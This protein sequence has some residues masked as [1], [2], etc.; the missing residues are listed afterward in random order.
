M[1]PPLGVFTPQVFHG[2]RKIN[3]NHPLPHSYDPKEPVRQK[4]ITET[5]ETLKLILPPQAIDTPQE[6]AKLGQYVVNIV[7]FRDPDNAITIWSN[8]DIVHRPAYRTT[9]GVD[10]PPSIHLPPRLLDGTIDPTFAAEGTDPLVHYG[11]EYQPVALNEVLAFQTQYA[12]PGATGTAPSTSLA[13]NVMYIELANTLTEAAGPASTAS[14]LD[15]KGW[16]FLLVKEDPT[17]TYTAADPN[18]RPVYV[19]PDPITGQTPRVDTST[20]TSPFLPED[21]TTATAV[22]G[23]VLPIIVGSGKSPDLTDLSTRKTVYSEAAA[24]LDPPVDAIDA[25]GKT[26]YTVLGGMKVASAPPADLAAITNDMPVPDKEFL[27]V[28]V[29]GTGPGEWDDFLP[30]TTDPAFNNPEGLYFWL[31]LRRPANPI[32]PPDPSTNPMVVVDSIR[33][34]FSMTDAK[35]ETANVTSPPLPPNYQDR[36]VAGRTP[37]QPLYSIER[38]QPFRGG[39]IVPDPEDPTRPLFIYG[40][41]LQARASREAPK[42]YGLYNTPAPEA[43]GKIETTLKLEQTIDRQNNISTL[44]AGTPANEAWDFM[45]FND[46]DFVSVAELMLVPAC[47][48]GLFTK[49]FAEVPPNVLAAYPPP[50]SP[51]TIALQTPPTATSGPIPKAGDPGVLGPIAHTQARTYPYLAHEFYYSSDPTYAIDPNGTIPPDPLVDDRGH[52]VGG[53]TAAG[54]HR[55]LGFFE[56][57]APNLGA[58]GPVAQGI[59]LDWYR[60]DRRP[61]LINPNLIVD[62]EVFFG[63][64]D[65]P[66]LLNASDFGTSR[67]PNAALPQ[68][69]TQVNVNG[70]PINVNSIANRGYTAF[71]NESGGITLAIDPLTGDDTST[72]L[73]Y[74]WSLMKVPFADF[75]KQRHGGSGFLFGFGDAQTAGYIEPI[76]PPYDPVTPRIPRDRPYRAMSYVDIQDSLLRPATLPP[77]PLTTLPANFNPTPPVGT[78][79]VADPGLKLSQTLAKDNVEIDPGF[80]YSFDAATPTPSTF[81]ANPVVDESGAE[82]RPIYPGI[83][84]RRLFQIPDASPP[85][86]DSNASLTGIDYVP[87]TNT[88]TGLFPDQAPLSTY[89]GGVDATLITDPVGPNQDMRRHPYYRTEL[90][91]KLTNL[92]TPRTHQFAV[93]LTVG[94][95]EV[96]ESG[97]RAQLVPDVMGPEIGGS[98]GKI[99]R[100][101]AFFVLDRSKAT[102]YDPRNPGDYRDVVLYSRRIE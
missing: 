78:R 84:P 91:Q 37:T 34:P 101:R 9:G 47:P 26:D 82:R 19:R 77:S 64:V 88:G 62:E 8:P 90:I 61:G 94:F 89:L 1:N 31:Y 13:A 15:L 18:F 49:Q 98:S 29:S 2:G 65:D 50:Q 44:S 52:I 96:A 55:M 12:D 76:I 66:R 73:N 6:V 57:P 14:D 97:D 81:Y 95:F 24:A 4:W 28:P 7:D 22:A 70:E 68:V 42:G 23:Q 36:L 20:V 75:L 10:V 58:I 43:S 79:V 102:G 48:P 53:P 54:W 87:I 21:A 16:D 92:T 72:S 17:T 38:P 3:L 39:Q 86:G 99:E 67:M 11:M 33:F 56:V 74:P 32:L 27:P 40:T 93:W 5:Y 41:S 83:P 46:R 45:P 85:S 51:T 100:Y 69:V 80:V 59:N 60:Q 63:L 25:D 30:D 71:T 35:G